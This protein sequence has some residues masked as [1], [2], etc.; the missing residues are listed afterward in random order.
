MSEVLSFYTPKG[1]ELLDSTE[2]TAEYS[3]R[4]GA[5]LEGERYVVPVWALRKT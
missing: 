1:F 3:R 4:E 2:V 5:L